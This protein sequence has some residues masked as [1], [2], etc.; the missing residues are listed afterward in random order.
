MAVAG[1]TPSL[2]SEAQSRGGT[3]TEQTRQARATHGH[4][5]RDELASSLG[6]V[7][8]AH[9]GGTAAAILA[10]ESPAE[11]QGRAIDRRNERAE[12]PTSP[13]LDALADGSQDVDGI[14]SS[15]A[16]HV[17]AHTGHAFTGQGPDQGGGLGAGATGDSGPTGPGK[18]DAAS[19][20]GDLRAGVALRETWGASVASSG[21]SGRESMA[22]K[23]SSDPLGSTALRGFQA[24]VTDEL[25]P[26]GP[27]L[28]A[29]TLVGG[30]RGAP[31]GITSQP[32]GTVHATPGGA[33]VDTSAGGPGAGQGWGGEAGSGGWSGGGGGTETKEAARQLFA[34]S[35]RAQ[36]HGAHESPF[37]IESEPVKAQIGRGLAQL[38]TGRGGAVTMRLNPGLLGEVRAQVE[39]LD[40]VAT[41][42]LETT[43][44]EAR[45]LLERDVASLRAS[46]ESRGLEVASIRI[47]GPAAESLGR[48]EAQGDAMT[49]DSADGSGDQRSD[50]ALDRD[51]DQ[52]G[53]DEGTGRKRSGG[54]GGGGFLDEVPPTRGVLPYARL[55]Q[56][57]WDSA[58]VM[59]LDA[60]A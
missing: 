13:L 53:R 50:H 16:H 30:Q 58:G 11:A 1:I 48:D 37:V 12:I 10:L 54:G 36:Q 5:F 49:E 23:E 4:S 59:R 24:P 33:P 34:S 45:A 27:R 14:G 38:L 51:P 32:G 31:A 26:A 39:I 18:Q 28:A 25:A 19:T 60:M 22:W 40:R 46:L 42:R 55:D 35:L 57:A 15:L 21:A 41:I 7:P 2:E 52:A 17:P 44:Q 3:A 20:P 29:A 8:I 47:E 6:G 43:T 56:A 9:L